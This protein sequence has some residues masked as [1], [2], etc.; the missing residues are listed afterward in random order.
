MRLWSAL[1]LAA[2]V[3]TAC[4]QIPIGSDRSDGGQ[5]VSATAPSPCKVDQDCVAFIDYCV[6]PLCGTCAAAAAATAATPGPV[7]RCSPPSNVRC[8]DACANLTA[9]CHAGFCALQ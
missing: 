2:V 6:G 3:M 5:E 7:S 8:D 4:A 9:I 1:A